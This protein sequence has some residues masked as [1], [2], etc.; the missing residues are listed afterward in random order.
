MVDH[1]AVGFIPGVEAGPRCGIVRELQALAG[2]ES[3]ARMATSSPPGALAG[4]ARLSGAGPP[5]TSIIG[6]L[7]DVRRI[8][9]VAL[10][11]VRVA[12]EPTDVLG[13]PLRRGLTDGT[14]FCTTPRYDP[15][16]SP[17]PHLVREAVQRA[18]SS[19]HRPASSPTRM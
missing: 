17:S 1:R 6:R 2:P 4:R 15:L 18:R 19:R 12:S 11:F 14:S 16:R 8:G 9:M 7:V 3:P 13:P 10:P 5:T